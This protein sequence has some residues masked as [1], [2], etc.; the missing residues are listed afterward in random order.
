M[1][2][3]PTLFVGCQCCKVLQSN[4]E[5]TAAAGNSR[6]FDVSGPEISARSVQEASGLLMQVQRMSNFAEQIRSGYM[7]QVTHAQRFFSLREECR[8]SCDVAAIYL[9]LTNAICCDGPYRQEIDLGLTVLEF[10]VDM[11]LLCQHL[12]LLASDDLASSLLSATFNSLHMLAR[13][14][15]TVQALLFS[16]AM[17]SQPDPSAG[18][19]DVVA[20]DSPYS[21]ELGTLVT[22]VCMFAEDCLEACARRHAI[23]ADLLQSARSH[24]RRDSF[25]ARTVTANPELVAM[26]AQNPRTGRQAHSIV[27]EEVETVP[28]FASLP[29]EADVAGMFSNIPGLPEQVHFRAGQEDMAFHSD[30]NLHSES[31][32]EQP[33]TNL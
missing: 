31:N 11:R 27:Y 24:R 21:Q 30:F 8:L 5:A 16:L 22:E 7:Q 19:D 6:G 33:H 18:P 10:L 29:G 26:F 4:D 28:T 9:A 1:F 13:L 17:E 23:A 2:I 14:P 3:L 15:A 20:L 12:K 32:M 25:F